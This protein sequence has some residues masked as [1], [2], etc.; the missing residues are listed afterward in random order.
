MAYN[1]LHGP[2]LVYFLDPTPIP[3]FVVILNYAF[4]S[5][6]YQSFLY[7]RAFMFSIHSASNTL[8]FLINTTPRQMS[9]PINSLSFSSNI[10]FSKTDQLEP[11]YF[12]IHICKF[13]YLI[14]FMC[15]SKINAHCAFT[16]I[17]RHV[18]S[19]KK[20]AL[21]DSHVAS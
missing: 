7:F 15:S 6:T 8:H 21:S 11:Y 20:L 17:H 16:V 5:E 18:Q 14:K 19:S 12:C 1:I 10:V 4:I 2:I 9:T 13:T 3:Y